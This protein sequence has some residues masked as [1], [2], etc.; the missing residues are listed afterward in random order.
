V[1]IAAE[2]R[3]IVLVTIVGSGM[4]AVES[5]GPYRHCPRCIWLLSK[6]M[7]AKLFDGG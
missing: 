5:A 2:L 4:A 7:L 3:V 1:R 6:L